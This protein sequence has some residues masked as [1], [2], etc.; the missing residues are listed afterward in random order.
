MKSSLYATY[1]TELIY[2]P[3][4][5]TQNITIKS[6]KPCQQKWVHPLGKVVNINIHHVNCQYFVWPPSLSWTAFTLLAIEFTRASQVATGMLF[7]SSMTTSRSWRIFETLRT[8]TFRLRIPQRCSIGFKSG[9]MLDQSIT[10]T[11]S[12][13]SKA[14]VVLEVCLGSLSCWNIALR[15]SFWREG[16]M[17]CCSISQYMLEFMFP[18]MKSNSPTPAALMQPQTMT[19]PPPCLTVGMTHLSL[20]FSPGH[21][22]TCLKPSEPN[23]LIFI[24]SDHRTWFQ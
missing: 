6:K 22:H 2:F 14:V 18:S 12:L 21:R 15:P 1:I 8:S 5:I 3:L 10:F 4:K 20:Y 19:F 24:S 7:H 13:F 16:I 11:L 23:K 17:L 9:D